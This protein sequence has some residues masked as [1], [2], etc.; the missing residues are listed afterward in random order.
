[1]GA[2]SPTPE[3]HEVLALAG[4]FSNS[5]SFSPSLVPTKSRGIGRVAGPRFTFPSRSNS[6]PWHGHSKSPRVGF[7]FWR[8]PKWVQ[9]SSNAIN[10]SGS[11]RFRSQAPASGTCN[12]VSS[13]SL[14]RTSLGTS[15]ALPFPVLKNANLASPP[16]PITAARPASKN[17]RDLRKN[18]LSVAVGS[19]KV[20]SSG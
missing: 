14:S 17:K 7:H 6:L 10:C 8:H 20:V 15:L 1:M 18:R 9:R 19:V 16:A 5:C 11:L 13:W 2:S 4:G 3:V 12:G